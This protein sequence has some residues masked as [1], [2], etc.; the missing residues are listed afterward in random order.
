MVL[1]RLRSRTTEWSRSPAYVRLQPDPVS[2]RSLVRL[3]PDVQLVVRIHPRNPIMVLVL[4]PKR[5]AKTLMALVLCLS[6]AGIAAECSLALLTPGSHP[7]LAE[8]LRKFQLDEELTV[9]AWYSSV[10]LL[11]CAGLLGVISYSKTKSPYFRHWAALAA[12]FV[13]LSIDEMAALHELLVAPFRG[14]LHTHGLLYYA[15]VIPAFAFV[16]GLT[17]VYWRFLFQH[18]DRKTRRR[19]VLAGCLFVA[20]ALGLEVFE[21]AIDEQVGRHNVRY[22]GLV[23][24]EETFEMLGVLIFMHALMAYIGS[25]LGE[26]RIRFEHEAGKHLVQERVVGSGIDQDALD[27]ASALPGDTLDAEQH[28][29]LLKQLG[30]TARQGV[31]DM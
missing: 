10:A 27:L 26:V 14:Q 24:V 20:G 7:G 16:C 23:V 2:L 30:A 29:V 15:W 9:P 8:L 25:N 11:A 21:G 19:F 1:F 22:Q 6:V 13:Y 31:N 3:K 5:V 12:L 18:L 28:A 17:L 4:N